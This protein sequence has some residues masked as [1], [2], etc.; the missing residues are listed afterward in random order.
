MNINEGKVVVA[1]EPGFR[2]VATTCKKG[3][4]GAK[5]YVLVL[6]VNYKKY[7]IPLD[8]GTFEFIN[9]KLMN[10]DSLIRMGDKYEH[11]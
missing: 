3:R 11:E 8:Q 9:Q 6:V 7:K 4:N 5:E 2:L 1:P 10:V